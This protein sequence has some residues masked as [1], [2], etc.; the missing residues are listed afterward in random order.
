LTVLNVQPSAPKALGCTT[1][2]LSKN[3]EKTRNNLLIGGYL[4]TEG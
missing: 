2:V 1:E 3:L 4:K